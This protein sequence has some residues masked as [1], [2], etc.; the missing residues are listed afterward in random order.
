MYTFASGMWVNIYIE[1]VNKEDLKFP[2]LLYVKS[3]I[4]ANNSKIHS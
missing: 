2:L 1:N 3:V 4:G